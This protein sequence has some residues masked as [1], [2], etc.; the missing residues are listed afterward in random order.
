MPETHKVLILG[1]GPAGLTAAL[2]SAGD[3]EELL[4][5][6]GDMAM[7]SV[8]LDAGS[9]DAILKDELYLCIMRGFLARVEERKRGNA[10]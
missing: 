10:R 3:S 4:A 6:F 8:D 1:S 2:S 5:D 9:E 7:A